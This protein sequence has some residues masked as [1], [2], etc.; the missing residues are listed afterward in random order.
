MAHAREHRHERADHPL[1]L[2]ASVL[3]RG[4][5]LFLTRDTGTWHQEPLRCQVPGVRHRGPAGARHESCARCQAPAGRSR[6]S[7]HGGSRARMVFLGFGKWARADR[8]Y[9]LEPL[10]GD[11]RG[12]GR[13]TRVWVEGVRDPVVASRTERT[14]LAEMGQDAAGDERGA[15][16]GARSRRAAR[17]RRG[18]R[19]RRPRRPRPPRAPRAREDRQAA[20]RPNSCFD[21]GGAGGRSAR[22]R[23]R[24]DSSRGSRSTSRRCASRAGSAASGSAS[25]SPTSRGGCC[26]CSRRCRCTASPARTSRSDCSRS[27]SSSRS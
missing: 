18:G 1:L 22:T 26:R 17:E 19:S 15:R 14:I 27:C 25:R 10:D 13:R 20:P 8:I 2:R 24:R 21:G 5:V 9:A 23:H 6:W 12:H 11:E 16:R 7:A 4:H 3:A